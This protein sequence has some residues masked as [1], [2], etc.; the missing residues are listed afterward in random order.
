MGHNEAIDANF[1]AWQ[2]LNNRY[3][4]SNGS[5]KALTIVTVL[6]WLLFFYKVTQTSEMAL[7]YSTEAQESIGMWAMVLIAMTC[8]S[9]LMLLLAGRVKRRRNAL[10]DTIRSDI[11]DQLSDA[12]PGMRAKLESQLREIGA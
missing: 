2:D 4:K 5:I 12:E 8:V 10:A 6:G 11:R 9:G 1:A 7:R 3:S